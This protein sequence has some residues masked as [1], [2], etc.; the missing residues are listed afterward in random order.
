MKIALYSDTFAPKIDGVANTVKNS[1]RALGEMGHEVR[2]YVVSEK[3][4]VELTKQANGL[5]T[6]I[7]IPSVSIP[8]YP[9]VRFSLPFGF[10]LFNLRKFRPDVV[11]V[12]TPFA[13][14]IEGVV[15][16]KIFG[17]PLV[18]THHTFFDYYLKHIYLDYNWAKKFSWRITV[19]FYNRVDL[20]ISPTKSLRDE[21]TS[22]GL[23][24]QVG[25]LSNSIDFQVFRND[26]KLNLSRLEL[27][28]KFGISGK[29]IVYM[30]RV[31][32]EK[33]IDDVV[34]AT[35]QLVK[36][37]PDI[38]L[39]IVGDGPEKE[40]LITMSKNLKIE[41]NVIFTG[42]LHNESLVKA[43]SANEV[44]VTASRSENM[45]LAVL[46]AESLG[47]PVVAISSLG[48]CEIVDDNVNGF[49]LPQG[50]KEKIVS[51]IA[52]AIL[53]FM[54]DDALLEKFSNN[55]KKLSEKYSEKEI[56]KKLVEIYKQIINTKP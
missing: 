24:K 55:S 2:V 7:T 53:K 54:T 4:G 31:S 11:H 32:Y 49:L 33:N 10:T 20:V 23:Y 36:K 18:G 43:L 5:Y 51:N 56:T 50:D 37:I 9:G 42:F 30:G 27:K 6:V 39:M 40:K 35:A 41:K 38:K 22:N 44:F 17:I 3:N 16:A 19:A 1:A 34:L 48:M 25:V 52:D 26:K 47:L 45:P 14:G 12:H 28:K 29:S 15:G 8:V 46:E 21:L 13:V